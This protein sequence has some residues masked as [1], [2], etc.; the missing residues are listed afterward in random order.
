MDL[1]LK[2]MADSVEKRSQLFYCRLIT[3]FNALIED[4]ERGKLFKTCLNPF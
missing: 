2:Y 3:L 4:S 1:F